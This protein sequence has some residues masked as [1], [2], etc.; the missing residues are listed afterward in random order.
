VT[1]C[2]DVERLQDADPRRECRSTPAAAHAHGLHPGPGVVRGVVECRR[3]GQRVLAAHHD[4][5]PP[6][7]GVVHRGAE[8]TPN[9]PRHLI[10]LRLV[11]VRDARLWDHINKM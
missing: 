1:R 5:T 10:L 2:L 3:L 9:G 7:G 4:E 8:P 11:E 6:R